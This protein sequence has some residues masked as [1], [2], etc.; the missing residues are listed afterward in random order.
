M[1][2]TCN[3]LKYHV[4]MEEASVVQAVEIK[5][6]PEPAAVLTKA[7]IRASDLLGLKDAELAR[8]IGV[9]PASVSRYRRGNA[10]IDPKRKEGELALLLVR[11]FRSLDPLV[12][13]N[14][15][16]R[17]AWMHSRSEVLRGVPARLILTPEGL[18]QTLAY[19]DGIRAPA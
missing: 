12:G 15:D 2:C 1:Y 11:L 19:V 17:R 5:T 7:T 9:S 10:E 6:R 13:S 8:T 4:P 16:Q 14:D 3:F 18:V